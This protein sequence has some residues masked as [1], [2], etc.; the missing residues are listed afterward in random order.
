MRHQ[1]PEKA[2]HPHMNAGRRIECFYPGRLAAD[3]RN[4]AQSISQQDADLRLRCCCRARGV[5]E[6]DLQSKN[7][8]FGNPQIFVQLTEWFDKIIME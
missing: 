4:H 5:T 2:L 1:V 6:A 7:A 8:K 3:K